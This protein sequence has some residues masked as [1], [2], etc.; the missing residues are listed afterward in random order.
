ML[1]GSTDKMARMW[2]IRQGQKKVTGS[3]THFS[4]FL[5]CRSGSSC[6]F[7]TK[8]RSFRWSWFSS[9]ILC[10]FL[11]KW[12]QGICVMGQERRD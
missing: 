8:Y 9:H 1:T 5:D 6:K 4:L 12:I 10:R 11:E 2:D 3:L 7:E